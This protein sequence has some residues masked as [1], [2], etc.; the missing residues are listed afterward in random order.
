MR[1]NRHNLFAFPKFNKAVLI[2]PS[3]IKTTA[4]V[5]LPLGEPTGQNWSCDKDDTLGLVHAG[6]CHMT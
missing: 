5:I 1:Q 4:G 6:P 2:L 3:E